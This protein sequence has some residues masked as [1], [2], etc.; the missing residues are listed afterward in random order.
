MRIKHQVMQ[1]H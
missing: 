1:K